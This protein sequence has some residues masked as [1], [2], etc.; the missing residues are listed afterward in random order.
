MDERPMKGS[1]FPQGGGELAEA[2]DGHPG[3]ERLLAYRDGE[4]GEEAYEE[5]QEH[6]SLCKECTGLLLELEQFRADAAAGERG[7]S[8]EERQA[9]WAA[10]RGELRQEREAQAIGAAPVISWEERRRAGPSWTVVALAAA[11]ALTVLG[12]VFVLQ[13]GK[14]LRESDQAHLAA[15]RR[16]AEELRARLEAVQQGA[17]QK[18]GS[19]TGTNPNP[20]PAG[21]RG[22]E[23]PKTKAPPAPDV[24]AHRPPAERPGLPP[25]VSTIAVAVGPWLTVRGESNKPVRLEAGGKVNTVSADE[26]GKI[27]IGFALGPALQSQNVRLQLLDDDGKVLWS[28]EKLS[29]VVDG[30]LGTAAALTGLQPGRYRL[31]AEGVGGEA[32]PEYVLEVAGK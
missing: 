5:I 24:L 10:L 18:E 31:Q 1:A 16:E 21:G 9:A 25:V 6:L 14:K 12:L 26:K 32:A 30:D 22:D 15:V 20:A 3:L 27:L 4:L 29:A 2:E 17:T 7:P 23:V 13:Q 8:E 28:G 19:E 11:L